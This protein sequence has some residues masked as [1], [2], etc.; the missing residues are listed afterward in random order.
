MRY[1]LTICFLSISI[2]TANAQQEVFNKLYLHGDDGWKFLD[3]LAL[4]G[5]DIL[6]MI[7]T[8]SGG[9]Q[10][11]D[12][13]KTDAQGNELWTKQ[14]SNPNSSSVIFGNLALDGPNIVMALFFDIEGA[15]SSI[16]PVY[17]VRQFLRVDTS[18]AILD[19]ASLYVETNFS[20]TQDM[21]SDQNGGFVCVGSGTDTMPV[22]GGSNKL[23]HLAYAF[24]A[25]FNITWQKLYLR[26]KLTNYGTGRVTSIVPSHNGGYVLLCYTRYGNSDSEF[27]L[28]ELNANGDS[29][30]VVRLSADSSVSFSDV[31]RTSD[32]GYLVV[33][34]QGED[35]QD[36]MQIHKVDSNLQTVWYRSYPSSAYG[37][38]AESVVEMPDGGYVIGGYIFTDIDYTINPYLAKIDANGDILWESTLP[39]GPEG[40][41]FFQHLHLTSN[42]QILAAGV[43]EQDN[44][45]LTIIIAQF[46]DTTLITSIHNA[47]L[48]TVTLYPNPTNNYLT[49][50]F[51]QPVQ[52]GTIYLHNLIGQ[53]LE[54]R[55]LKGES[56][57]MLSLN[58]QAGIYF[59]TL[60][61]P[62]GR[63]NYKVFKE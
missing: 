5:G 13:V 61:T 19:S 26:Y 45:D 42:N 21:I 56:S 38:Y 40:Y 54:Q 9:I 20:S 41:D 37:S 63:W 23:T 24:D 52:Q 22:F 50:Q 43:R 12:L 27:D 15:N 7:N 59:I 30:G 31:I 55:T 11:V 2:F 58:G 44:N 18:G 32:G 3:I 10:S 47:E 8:E 25:D 36:Y 49:V 39:T 16:Y 17:S 34:S 57:I 60:E 6:Y 51:E 33:G 62:N 53:Q 48:G 35:L 4:P 28:L 46:I 1:L 14:Y 29:I